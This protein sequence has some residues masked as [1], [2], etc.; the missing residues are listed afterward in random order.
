MNSFQIKK[1][2]NNF[3]ILKYKHYHGEKWLSGVIPCKFETSEKE[4]VKLCK[5]GF[6]VENSK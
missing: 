1:D 4:K 3:I 5:Y 6:M 2:G